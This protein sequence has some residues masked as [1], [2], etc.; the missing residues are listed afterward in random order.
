MEKEWN[1]FYVPS[2]NT[3]MDLNE[4]GVLDVAFYQGTK[5]SPAVAGVT[6]VDVSN[7][8]S[9]KTNSQKLKNGT[10]GELIWLKEISRKWND[11]QYY[12]PIPQT[13]VLRNPALGQNPG[14]F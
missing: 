10:S 11:K 12:Y 13:D 1:G 7:Q 4:D 3:P 6:Y 14:W 8:I 9:G 5:P 2:L